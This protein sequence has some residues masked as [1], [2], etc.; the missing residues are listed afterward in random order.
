MTPLLIAAGFALAALIAYLVVVALRSRD[1][2]DRRA[3]RARATEVL[4]RA[5]ASVPANAFDARLRIL[6]GQT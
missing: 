6:R 4:Q 1:P 3:T 2:L 5:V